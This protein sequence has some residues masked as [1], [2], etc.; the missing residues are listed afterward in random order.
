MKNKIRFIFFDDSIYFFSIF[1]IEFYIIRVRLIFDTIKLDGFVGIFD[2]MPKIFAPR[3][4]KE[5]VNHEP[6]KPVWPV[7]MIFLFLKTFSKFI[8]FGYD[9][10]VFKN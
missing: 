4:F 10:N 1:Y 9:K 6:L 2:E 5:R 7:I 8:K 3:F